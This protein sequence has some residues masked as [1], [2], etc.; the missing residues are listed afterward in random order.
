MVCSKRSHLLHSRA[1]HRPG[2][3][4][5]ED[6]PALEARRNQGDVR[7]ASGA[8]RREGRRHGDA[9][10]QPQGAPGVSRG[11]GCYAQTGRPGAVV[12]RLNAEVN[13]APASPAVK[14]RIAAP[15]AMPAPMAP[16]ESTAKAEEDSRRFG[17]IIRQ[18]KIV[19]DWRF[20]RPALREPVAP[21]A[22]PA[23]SG[24]SSP[25]PPAAGAATGSRHPPA[26]PPPAWPAGCP[27]SRPA[28]PAVRR[29]A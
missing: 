16:A 9:R 18:R 1:L 13:H 17:A 20:T 2:I 24:R 5:H 28:A 19:G 22:P 23:H 8:G 3:P 12:A 29:P 21:P 15:G 10:P 4:Q 11:C 25:A 14:D 7:Q 6:R 26:R 27:A